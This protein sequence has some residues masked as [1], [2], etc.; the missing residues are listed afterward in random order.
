MPPV[1]RGL[2]GKSHASRLRRPQHSGHA[3]GQDAALR[4]GLRTP[5]RCFTFTEPNELKSTWDS[6]HCWMKKGA[7]VSIY[8]ELVNAPLAMPALPPEAGNR[9][10]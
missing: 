1:A 9:T 6:A 7:Q 2:L 4:R 8:V 5:S 3:T 10:S